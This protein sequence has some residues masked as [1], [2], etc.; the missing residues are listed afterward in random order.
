MEEILIMWVNK[1]RP[2]YNYEEKLDLD[3]R[4][5]QTQINIYYSIK[6]INRFNGGLKR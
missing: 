3:N 4:H 5:T 6:K 2:T 1:E